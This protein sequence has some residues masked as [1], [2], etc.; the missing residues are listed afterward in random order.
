VSSN[1]GTTITE[2]DF[3]ITGNYDFATNTPITSVTVGGITAPVVS[4]GTATSTALIPG[5]NIA[6][7]AGNQGLDIPVT[8][9]VAPVGTNG[10]LSNRTAILSITYVKY[11]SGGQTLSFSPLGVVA[12][13]M[14]W[15]LHPV[16]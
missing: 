9:N 6:V 8:V 3:A 2:L 1:G 15:R 12:P 4:A 14:T 7:P 16:L 13:T 5:L 11:T 10:I